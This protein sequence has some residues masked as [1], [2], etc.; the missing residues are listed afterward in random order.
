MDAAAKDS[1]NDRITIR[2]RLATPVSDALQ[3]K[4][5]ARA[6]LGRILSNA[7]LPE[8]ITRLIEG[9]VRKSRL[10]RREKVDVANELIAHFADGLDAG[11][12][13]E[14]LVDD[15]G[16]PIRAA[17]LIRR[18]MKRNRPLWWRTQRRIGHGLGLLALLLIG[19][20]LYA[21]ILY[22]TGSPRISHDFLA[23]LNALPAAAPQAE[24]A[25]PLYRQALLTLPTEP[26][27]FNSSTP[28][29]NDPKWQA[30]L[31]YLAAHDPELQLVR[32]AADK[33]ALGFLAST[34]ID[35]LD[36]PLWP[37]LKSDADR[38]VMSVLLPHLGSLRRVARI[39]DIDIQRAAAAGDGA[40]VNANIFAI[41]GIAEHTR[42]MP[43]LI[44][45]L[46]SYAIFGLAVED[47]KQIL[48]DSP[49]LL[50]DHQLRDLA[51]RISSFPGAAGGGAIRIRLDGER[52]FF[53]DFV[54]R[55]Y[56]DD[57]CGDG[58]L[59][60]AGI[61]FLSLVQA[62]NQ[63]SG[64]E[65]EPLAPLTS[66]VAAGRRDVVAEYNKMM[67]LLESDAAKPMWQ[68]DH[69]AEQ[70]VGKYLDSIWLR[71]RYPPMALLVPAVSKAQVQGELMSQQR[72][73]ALLAIALELHHRRHGHWPQSL[74]ELAPALLPQVPV[75]RFDGQPIRYRLID[76]KPLIYSVGSDRDD[77]AG[78]PPREADGSPN[79][80]SAARWIS[81]G[82][83]AQVKAGQPSF[84]YPTAQQYPPD[85]DWI[86]WPPV[87]APPSQPGRASL[88][89]APPNN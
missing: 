13:P 43:V 58:R 72:D 68:W 46:V 3:G 87:P 34:S 45:D 38:G 47:L 74:T 80:Q 33:P 73:A 62:A 25:W 36:T 53:H 61:E 88:M 79:N 76:G 52:M 29:H 83:L 78:Q 48:A 5:R 30:W 63:M 86:L 1:S 54:Q 10:W 55:S 4:W 15:F 70:E 85:G 51:H 27:H 77:D 6:T 65:F 44:N 84:Q 40:A 9:I 28:N 49:Q 2:D 24:R 57:G 59:T 50:N 60:D 71:M 67:A 82:K 31:E 17:A 89:I 8:S 19:I 26:E 81:A 75:D 42:E 69:P 20:Y 35:P 11:R 7:G 18:A 39:L 66:L 37:G 23:D 64:Y 12:T 56:T 41:I 16:D 21:L 22:L 14:Q 32:Q